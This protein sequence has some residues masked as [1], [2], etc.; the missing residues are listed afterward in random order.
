MERHLLISTLIES[1][2]FFNNN[3]IKISEK[4]IKSL[5][6]YSFS[7]C[8]FYEIDLERLNKKLELL[9]SMYQDK[10]LKVKSKNKIISNIYFFILI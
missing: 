3:I 7:F 2:I 5:S 10:N 6:S 8:L 4:I 9:A 1:I